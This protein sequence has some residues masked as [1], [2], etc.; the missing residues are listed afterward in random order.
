MS[1]QFIDAGSQHNVR[2]WIEERIKTGV[3]RS[4]MN[5]EIRP[6]SD[7]RA[8][9][10]P[11]YY[12]VCREGSFAWRDGLTST[13]VRYKL[14]HFGLQ[15]DPIMCP[16][17]CKYYR[18]KFLYDVKDKSKQFVLIC[19]SPFRAIGAAFLKLPENTQIVVIVVLLVLTAIWRA[20]RLL[21]LLTNLI[22]A[23]TGH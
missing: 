19:W 16:K 20:P 2:A 3:L 17:N 13:D 6:L 12:P 1:S 4:C 9:G 10:M 5:L 15:N 23:A 11:F 7:A 14:L 18:S 21:P 8:D 22:R